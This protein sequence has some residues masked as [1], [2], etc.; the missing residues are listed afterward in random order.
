M[1]DTPN[2]ERPARLK[3]WRLHRQWTQGQAAL[4]YGVT[5]RTWR[6]YERGV[7]HVPRPLINRIEDAQAKTKAKREKKK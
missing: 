1:L 6:R 7:T 4:W 3:A 2:E 5:E